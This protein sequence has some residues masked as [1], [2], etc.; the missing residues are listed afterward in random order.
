MAVA[1]GIGRNFPTQSNFSHHLGLI[2]VLSKLVYKHEIA[3]EDGFV[4]ESGFENF[5]QV[6]EGRI[7]GRD[8]NGHVRANANGLLLMPLYQK[9]GNEGFFI[10]EP[11]KH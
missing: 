1:E 2:F 4:M 5:D 6:K 3:P 8:Q 10:I 9:K 7:L 11:I